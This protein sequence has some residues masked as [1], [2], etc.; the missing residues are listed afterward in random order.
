MT[1]AEQEV[2]QKHLMK[3]MVREVFATITVDDILRIK[4]PN[5]WEWKGKEVPAETVVQLQTQAKAFS[6]SLLWK[7]LK[8]E[9]QWHAAK[10]LLEDG[11][12]SADVRAAQ[13]LGYLTTIL[14]TK[15]KKM[16]D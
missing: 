9:L 13:L 4:A 14:D 2:L 5:V 8:A 16:G 12:T 10:N 11:K 7:M 1:D 15:L 6:E 3:F